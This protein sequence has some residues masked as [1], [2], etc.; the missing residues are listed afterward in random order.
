M[1]ILESFYEKV[2]GSYLILVTAVISLTFTLISVI[3]FVTIN[4]AF[5][6][7]INW[8][9][10]PGDTTPVV[11]STVFNT[12]VLV[13]C[14]LMIL[15][16][17]YI[18]MYLKEK[19]CKEK[20]VKLSLFFGL[21]SSI[22]ELILGL[23]PNNVSSDI[24]TVA[25][26]FFFIGAACYGIS[27]G[28]TELKSK[29]LPRYLGYSGFIMSTPFLIFSGSLFIITIFPSLTYN[30]AIWEW[31]SYFSIIGWAIIHGNFMYRERNI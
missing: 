26:L 6:F 5:S 29:T 15:I 13:M 2:N 20:L 25:A 31:L 17:L 22:G 7:F 3:L 10:T 4:P 1:K 11:V 14:P 12:G 24:H 27:Y 21:M 19:G 28:T 23:I 8:L 18:F 30:P 16:H 9:P